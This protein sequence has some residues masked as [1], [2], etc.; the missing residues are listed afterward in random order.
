MLTI[1]AEPATDASGQA[2][3]ASVSLYRCAKISHAQDG[4]SLDNIAHSMTGVPA[5]IH[6]HN[7]GTGAVYI[8]VGHWSTLPASRPIHHHQTELMGMHLENLFR[9][10]GPILLLLLFSGAC[11]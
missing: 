2:Y 10:K 8:V 9:L 3:T 6:E 1:R 5:K 7:G 11:S 4:S